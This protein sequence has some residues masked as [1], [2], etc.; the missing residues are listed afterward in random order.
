MKNF[1]TLVAEAWE[2]PFSGWDFSWLYG[3]EI[4][5]PSSWD[6]PALVKARIRDAQSVLDMGTGEGEFFAHLAPFPSVAFAT[7]G[8]PPNVPIAQARLEPLGVEVV[9]TF[10][11]GSLPFEDASFDLVLNRHESFSAEEVERI[12]KPGGLFLTQQV[13]GKNAARLNKLL[14]DRPEHIYSPWDLR[15]ASNQILDAGIDILQEQE[16][17]PETIFT[18]IGAVVYYL[19]TVPWQIE[20]FEPAKFMPQLARIDQMIRRDGKLVIPM[21]RFFIEACKPLP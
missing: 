16:E 19:K 18:D 2:A 9:Q 8:F 5:Q 17:F 21:H 13:G 4:T 11:D 15:R 6:Y 1:A 7:E 12:L 10:Q 14:E 20:G 3:R